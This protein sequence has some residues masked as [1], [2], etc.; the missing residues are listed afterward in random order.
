M[1]RLTPLLMTLV[2]ASCQAAPGGPAPVATVPFGARVLPGPTAPDPAMPLAAVGGTAT[3]QGSYLPHELIVELAPTA[4]AAAVARLAEARLEG[5]LGLGARYARL[6]FAASASLGAAATALAAMPGVT[7]VSVNWRTTPSYL[8]AG[9]HPNDPVRD[10][11]WAL[12]VTRAEAGWQ[13]LGASFSAANTVLAVLDTGCDRGHPDLVGRVLPGHNLVAEHPD[14]TL[15]LDQDVTDQVGHGTHVSGIAAARGDNAVGIA[16]IAWDAPILPVKVLGTTGGSTFGAAQGVR[17]AADWASGSLRVRVINMSLGSTGRITTDALMT[18]AIDYAWAR[19]VVVVAA[20]GN[21]GTD[22]TIPA[23][24]RHVV[25]VS[26][27]AAFTGGLL[28]SEFFAGFSNRG[29]RI[30]VAAPG[31]EIASTLPRNDNR[32]SQAIGLR[33]IPVG[34]DSLDYDPPYGYSSGTSMASPL[35]AGLATLLMARHDPQHAQRVGLFAER[36][37]ERLRATADDLG[38]AGRDP[39]YGSGRI[40][41]ARALAPGGF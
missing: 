31:G 12:D 24:C 20:A 32:L 28:T 15:P 9:A 37:A 19:G 40:N 23:L 8:A 30:D 13:A 1:R 10:Q 2:L 18:D 29:A 21:E 39:L 4:D 17:Y 16:G 27:T 35:V 14:P 22:L 3:S 7:G 36:V 11:Q 26:A 33:T 34:S 25:A 41:L 6:V 38:A 5:E